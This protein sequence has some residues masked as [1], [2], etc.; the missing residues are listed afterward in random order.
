MILII[1]LLTAFMVLAMCLVLPFVAHFQTPRRNR[2]K[3]QQVED[4]ALWFAV[5]VWLRRRV[6]FVLDYLVHNYHAHFS[7]LRPSHFPIYGKH[8][9]PKAEVVIVKPS[10]QHDYP[11]HS[12]IS[13]LD[14]A[15]PPSFYCFFFEGLLDREEVLKAFGT[16]LAQTPTVG[17]R[18]QQFKTM[19]EL[20]QDGGAA[21]WF[22]KLSKL[23]R[24]IVEMRMKTGKP[25]PVFDLRKCEL[26][27]AFLEDDT[28]KLEEGIMTASELSKHMDVLGQFTVTGPLRVTCPNEID[29]LTRLQVTHLNKA[30]KTAL[31][32]SIEHIVADASSV[33]MF[34]GLFGD[35]LSGKKDGQILPRQDAL[36]LFKHVYSMN[37]ERIDDFT[38][39]YFD[40]TASFSFFRCQCFNYFESKL[41]I[42]GKIIAKEVTIGRKQLDDLKNRV[43]NENELLKNEI[44]SS[45]DILCAI[46]WKSV[47]VGDAKLNRFSNDKLIIQR[48]VASFRDRC[49]FVSSNYFGNAFGIIFNSMTKKQLLQSK[50][51][52]L[53]LFMKQTTKKTVSNPQFWEDKIEEMVQRYFDPYQIDYGFPA[54]EGNDNYMGV[55]NWV[56]PIETISKHFS[57]NCFLGVSALPMPIP[58]VN[59][60]IPVSTSDPEGGFRLVLSMYEP[61]YVYIL[62][63]LSSV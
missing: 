51:S 22:D 17:A 41:K 43:V 14:I 9:N 34:M 44:V 62:N 15:L 48:S 26:E 61:E 5:V 35:A 28:I 38:Y 55:T 10:F 30:R 59:K 4:V 63:E 31:S 20:R 54:F 46:M 50:I 58:H 16:V 49:S 53:V 39:S 57:D 12:L 8:P 21:D 56:K 25:V 40:P 52:D 11:S 23:E 13:P 19:K 24:Q 33:S 27:V 47:A 60:I 42:N 37:S 3:L 7:M 36:P 1:I 45:N 6:M 2:L 29:V 18:V 32:L